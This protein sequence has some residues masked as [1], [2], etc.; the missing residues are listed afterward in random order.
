VPVEARDVAPEFELAP[1]A[2]ELPSP[3]PA[4]LEPTPLVLD[5]P[6]EFESAFAPALESAVEGPP[7]AVASTASENTA[8]LA[9]ARL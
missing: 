4:V 2:V 5:A 6:D 1:V 8:A 7:Q 3:L 9:A